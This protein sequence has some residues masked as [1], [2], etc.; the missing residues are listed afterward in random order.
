MTA[1]RELE[2]T[3]AITPQV[4]PA[5][6]PA[7]GDAVPL[8]MLLL[9]SLGGALEFYDFVVFVFFT[10]AIQTL[11]FA[12]T[13]PEWVRLAQ[14]YG[15][16]AAGYFARPVGG[17]LMAHYGDTQGR[18]RV[19]TFSVLLMALPTLLIGCLPV[20]KTIGA[21]A[22][23]LLLLLR[24]MQG[25][26]IG[27]EAPGAW[28]YASEHVRRGRTGLAIGLLTGG[29]CLGILL[30]SLMAAGVGAVFTPHAVLAWAWRIPFV[31]GGVLGLG[32]MQLRRQLAETPVFLEMQRQAALSR[33]APVAVLLRGNG[34]AIIASV[35]VTWTLTAAIVAVILLTPTLLPKLLGLPPAAVRT[36]SLA[37]TA[38]LCISNVLIGMAADRFG[39]RRVAV[40]ALLFLVASTYA[41]YAG[42]ALFPSALLPLFVLAGVGAGCSVLTPLL[43][44]RAFPAAIR[45][46]GVS[47]TYNLA[48]A[49]F[50]GLTP[51]LVLWLAHGSRLGPAHYV[52]AASLAG[53]C[54]M[55]M[56]HSENS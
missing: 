47:F 32:A 8:K 55:L 53:L 17:I 6:T 50:G 21:A 13:S 7:S 25:A 11:F 36:A 31:S 51:P 3:N 16:F 38:A 33:R 34:P 12:P 14:T 49:L 54:A 19:F 45:F 5:Q 46:T 2:G 30:G 15:L 52:A 37:A 29:L 48:Y 43:L 4:I 18:K 10:T 26:A 28:V 41:L 9:A 56:P 44:V 35:A 22:P 23:L 39:L 24:L 1:P 27:G 42:A 20:Y 40:P